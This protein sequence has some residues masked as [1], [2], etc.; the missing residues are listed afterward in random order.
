MKYTNIDVTED[1]L[2]A[3]DLLK[4]GAPMVVFDLETTGLKTEVDRILSFS[5]AKIKV[6]EGV[7]EIEDEID[8]FIN[9]GFHIPEEA[10]AKNHILDEDVADCPREDEAIITIRKFL[11]ERP[12]LCGYNSKNFDE[13]FMKAMYKRC[14]GEEFQP[15]FHVDVMQMAKQVCEL[16][17]YSLENVAHELG[18][19]GGLTFHKSMDDVMAT[20]RTFDVLKVHYTTAKE[21]EDL[22]KVKVTK[23]NFWQGPNHNLVRIYVSTAPSLTGKVYYD[24]Y[25]KEWKADEAIDLKDVREQSFKLMDVDNEKDLIAKCKEA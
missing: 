11:G 10:S 14:L 9:P 23:L 2:N 8:L 1:V 18:V 4:A 7:P 20:F 25:R 5:A 16:N 13:K 3:I 6:R 19:D 17:S 15:Y 21:E 24:C 22:M 12:F